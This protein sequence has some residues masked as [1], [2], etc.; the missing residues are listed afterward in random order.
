MP[1]SDIGQHLQISLKRNNFRFQDLCKRYDIRT[2]NTNVVRASALLA[3]VTH[4]VSY[5]RGA[6]HSAVALC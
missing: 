3:S 2:K 4:G 6:Y 1:S 5:L